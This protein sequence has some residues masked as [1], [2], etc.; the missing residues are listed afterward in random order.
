MTVKITK[1]RVADVL[2]AV[3]SLV[4][5]EVLIGIPASASAR[6]DSPLG[7]AGIGYLME[8]GSPSQ[9]IPPRPHLVPGIETARDKIEKKMRAGAK[10]ALD[11]KTADVNAALVGAG[12]VAERAVKAK[13]SDGPFATLSPKTLAKRRAKGRP[14][15]KPLIDTG[16]YRRAIT[17]VV[18]K[19]GQ[20]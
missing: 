2:K 7:H 6:D 20:S 16:E 9:N 11:G 17:H 15:E 3:Q 5:S 10:A 8:T 4:K 14:G 18:R 12:I 19:K 13:I 1:D